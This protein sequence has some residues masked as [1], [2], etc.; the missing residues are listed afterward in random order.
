LPNTAGHLYYGRCPDYIPLNYNEGYSGQ[1]PDL[2]YEFL[3]YSDAA[4][5]L[6]R[7]SGATGI[8][9]GNTRAACYHE[10]TSL[11]AVGR[12]DTQTVGS[13]PSFAAFRKNMRRTHCAYNP[14]ATDKTVTFTD[15]FSMLVPA[16]EQVC[17]TAVTGTTVPQPAAA[18]S[19]GTNTLIKVFA[20][21]TAMPRLDALFRKAAALRAAIYDLSGKKIWEFRVGNGGFPGGGFPR[22][23]APG[24]YLVKLFR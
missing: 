10:L 9:G 16:G 20:A 24:V 19:S 5:A 2:F 3:A 4:T 1:W 22:L 13:V 21:G 15:G 12:L 18:G 23:P 11:N 17:R 7:Y 14:D 8:E 6:G